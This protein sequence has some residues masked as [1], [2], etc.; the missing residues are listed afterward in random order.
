MVQRASVC[1][2]LAGVVALH[3][4]HSDAQ[5]PRL[6]GNAPDASLHAAPLL[7][8]TID[9]KND[10]EALA[11]SSTRQGVLG[12]GVDSSLKDEE[13]QAA[14]PM[15]HLRFSRAELNDRPREV[16]ERFLANNGG[17]TDSS[18]HNGAL[19]THLVQRMHEE[20]AAVCRVEELDFLLVNDGEPQQGASKGG[21]GVAEETRGEYSG[22]TRPAVGVGTERGSLA[23]PP[24]QGRVLAP[25]RVPP[26]LWSA[27]TSEG[28]IPVVRWYFNEST[29]GNLSKSGPTKGIGFIVH[30]TPPSGGPG[31]PQNVAHEADER[32][33]TSDYYRAQ[34]SKA[35]D[36]VVGGG[37]Y[38]CTDEF[39]YTALDH[40]AG[41]A[42][43]VVDGGGG[44]GGG[45][46]RGKRVG[47]IGSARP[48]YEMI[49]V[50]EKAEMTTVIEYHAISPPS[51]SVFVE[52]TVAG[53]V[54]SVPL[55]DRLKYVTPREYNLLQRRVGQKNAGVGE[56]EHSGVGEGV[57]GEERHDVQ[58]DVILSI[59]SF[60]HD[61]LGRYGDPVDP[62]ADL[63]SMSK[64]RQMLSPEGLLF[65]AVPIGRDCVM[66][67][68]HRV[69]GRARL[70][71]RRHRVRRL[72]G[73]RL[74]RMATTARERRTLASSDPSSD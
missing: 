3:L 7:F 54:V 19:V 8:L 21:R 56:G 18:D 25:T 41:P 13:A 65:L 23:A 26:H 1:I 34:L 35:H 4:L 2:I 50:A 71:R 29:E 45:T 63:R 68:A 55:R 73:T 47:V 17:L 5:R 15:R 37:G 20:M 57:F 16:A 30:T 32:Y 46:L 74:Q 44:G 60:E 22:G 24:E 62:D 72:C 28:S 48:W 39:L 69:Y 6:C 52:A 58:F 43:T 59:S 64:T 9:L 70:Q 67:N 31:R 38:G 51:G 10:I 49:S 12:A 66:W 14:G 36:R 33:Y 42:L 40:F 27:Y 61:G 11:L 53:Q